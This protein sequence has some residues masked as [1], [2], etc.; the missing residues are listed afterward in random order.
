VDE[1]IA[2]LHARLE[3]TERDPA[4]GAVLKGFTKG[5]RAI[6]ATAEEQPGW[7][8]H[9][10][11]DKRDLDERHCDEAMQI[12][13]AEILRHLAAAWEGHPDF[14]DKWQSNGAAR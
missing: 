11:D 1:L 2:F 12:L 3:E 7:H 5:T 10:P 6:L 14:R 8:L 13:L 4:S 9:G